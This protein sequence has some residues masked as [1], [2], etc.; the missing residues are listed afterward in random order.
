MLYNNFI[1]RFTAQLEAREDSDDLSNPY[2]QSRYSGNLGVYLDALFRQ[3]GRRILIVGEAL[4]YRGGA[5]T[6]IPFSSSRLVAYSDHPFWR[7]LRGQVQ[8]DSDI[9][10]ATASIVWE[11]LR[12]RRR[13]PLFWNALPFHPHRKGDLA[14]NRAPNA[15]EIREGAH[16]L[17][18]LATEYQPDLV[19]GLG[20]KGTAAALKA[21]PE[22]KVAALRHP[23][24]GGKQSF[25][26]GMDNLL[27]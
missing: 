13:I 22:F 10:E 26:R 5:H 6:G 15:Q 7:N 9:S 27:R 12:A 4:G 16:I 19:A 3:P 18:T 1:S 24:Y 21:L 14:S 25:C 23:S 17:Q 11:Y 8:V 20:H 2:R